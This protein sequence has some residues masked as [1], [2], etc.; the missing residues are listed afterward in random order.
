MIVTMHILLEDVVYLFLVF[1]GKGAVG[2]WVFLY[3]RDNIF[4]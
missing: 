2:V 3:L 4:T 1:F